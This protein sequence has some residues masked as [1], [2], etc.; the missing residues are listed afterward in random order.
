M[1]RNSPFLSLSFVLLLSIANDVNAQEYG[2]KLPPGFKISLFAD[3]NLAN[4][5]YCMTLDDKGRVIVTGRGYVRR[6]IDEDGDGKAEKSQ[7]LRETNTGGMGMCWADDEKLYFCGDGWFARVDTRWPRVQFT[8]ESGTRFA[9][10][11]FGE[12]GGHAPRKGPD[13]CWYIIAGNDAGLADVKLD[14]F[15][16][17]K[18]PEAGGILRFSKDMKKVECIAQGFRNPYDFD[19]TPLGDII[20][21]DSDTERDFLLPWY[22][23]T[24]IYH[25]AHGQH[26]GWRLPGY[27]QSLARR[28]YY[29]DS[30]DILA[31][32]GRGSPTGVVCY[33]HYQF[34]KR[35]W[36]GV[37]ALDWTFG[38]IWFLPLEPDGSSYKTKPEVFLEPIGDN[39]FAPTDACVAPDGSLFV[40]IGGRGTR[41]AVYRI[42]YVGTKDSPPGKWIEPKDD[43]D[44]DKVLE[45]PQPLDEWSRVKYQ[46]LFWRIS[47]RS[48][49]GSALDEELPAWK[50]IRA[51]EL[52]NDVSNGIPDFDAAMKLAM[53]KPDV[54][55]A[56]VAWSL[57][58]TLPQ[59]GEE[60]LA[61]LA[62]DRSPRVRVE[63]LNALADRPAGGG[64]WV[65]QPRLLTGLADSLGHADKRVRLAAARVIERLYA[66]N[67][68]KLQVLLE[69][70]DLQG[71][72]MFAL[73]DHM[74]VEP[75]EIMRVEKFQTAL[76]GI[77]STNEE[78]RVA[79]LRLLMLLDG[80]WCLQNPPKVVYSA[81]ALQKPRNEPREIEKELRA[82]LR[83]I[84][85]TGDKNFDHEAARYF[86]M[87]ED[88]DPQTV[89]KVLAQIT[90]DSPA[91]DDVHHLIVL[92][93]LKG[94]REPQQTAAVVNALMS[95]EKKWQ[96]YQQKIKQNWA[97]RL[98]EVVVDLA[99]KYPDFP[100]AMLKHP[101]FVHPS[102]VLFTSTFSA[103]QRTEA[104]R[105]YFDA[106]KKNDD[107]FWSPELV[108]LLA[109]LPPAEYKPLF[110][111]RW[112]DFS[113]RDA[114]LQHLLKEPEAEDRPRFLDGLESAQRRI[115]TDCLDA[116][117]R[118]PRDTSADNVV[119]ILRRLNAEIAD[120]KD[121]RQREILIA[122]FNWQMGTN[123]A[124]L[125]VL[126]AE[127]R[128]LHT[129]P[130]KLRRAYS[131]VFEWFEKQH[132]PAA[133][134]LRAGEED[135]DH[136]QK[137]LA[138]APWDK[139]DAL[140]GVKIFQQRSCAACHT[141]TS[142]IG[143]DLTGI[144]N[145]FSRDDLFTAILYPSRDVAPAF[146]VDNIETQDGKRFAG[147]VVFESADGVIVQLDAV[148]TVRIDS[149]NIASRQPG[150]KS[151]MPAG[152]LKDL[153]PED[154]A[155]LYAYLKSL[156]SG[157]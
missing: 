146:R 68:S 48:L 21:Y 53:V 44:L 126:F 109:T 137:Q 144:A 70:G 39:G 47:D 36:G 56:R 157:P 25:V 104:A 135:A 59:G 13:G 79:A 132:P 98:L 91:R 138:A 41:G 134:L 58:R 26:H 16:P 89:A 18:N 11:R 131:V 128:T 87:I 40:S 3:H 116:L 38:K 33:R 62:A 50:R 55:R 75:P 65:V 149:G 102:H 119:P 143:A 69:N 153:K 151:L 107:Y 125:D 78:D 86:A 63:A 83:K 9:K 121:A 14:P 34:P 100:E 60:A 129:D 93:R 6:L 124:D 85:P 30:V 127:P 118:L 88:H 8:D 147:I 155:D 66:R 97:A 77:R 108:D 37:F 31:P 71:R 22:S 110:R 35:F 115:A 19:F 156:K 29:P 7:Q 92:G 52:L 99:K 103:G 81:Y 152:L 133:K 141:G 73:A 54:V 49:I 1:S 5:I 148:N 123:F 61:R 24:R 57:G 142:R 27:M 150:R 43:D 130:A 76:D 106:V 112:S 145:R 51:I 12:H 28:D 94:K 113:L 120:G 122:L 23:P 17:I 80:D 96:G 67:W 10:L 136:W 64:L 45:M 46:K 72:L 4:D 84:Y 111:K 82:H 117:A 90:K 139:G 20:T 105:L 114:M 32:I 101:A 42:E 95:L 154:L 140:R 2:V 15:S 74:H